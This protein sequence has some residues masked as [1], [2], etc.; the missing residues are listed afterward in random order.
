MNELK[1]SG[2]LL[3]LFALRCLVP[4]VFVLTIGYVMNWLVERWRQ[5]D[6]WD[7]IMKR[8]RFCDAYT[9]YGSK[10]WSARLAAE[11]ALPVECV[12]CPIYKK[13]VAIV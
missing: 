10:C 8:T 1:A 9:R 12:D 7:A 13:A 6:E 5:Q 2:I 4:I 11:G 3:L